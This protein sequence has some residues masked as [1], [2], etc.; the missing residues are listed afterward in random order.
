[1]SGVVHATFGCGWAREVRALRV[2]A[3]LSI[4]RLATAA[5]IDDAYLGQIERGEREPS[6]TVLVAI[7]TALGGDASVRLYPGTGPRLRDPIQARIVEAILR[8]ADPHWIRMV[9]VVVRRPVRG[10]IDLVLRDPVEPTWIAIEIH[11]ELRRLEQQLRWAN[12]KA[13][14]LPSSD[15]WPSSTTI[16]P[17]IHRVLVL[18]RTRANRTL[19]TRFEAML[20]AAYPA[21]PTDAYR[22]LTRPDLPWPGSAF[23]WATVDGDVTRISDRSIA[24]PRPTRP[25]RTAPE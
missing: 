3:G 10:V 23:L 15:A 20:S 16:E 4:R 24:T 5:R 8:T 11:S 2:D 1:M 21:S 18:R 19:A 25:H 12:E 14:A 17:T 9:E 6:L 22:A 13:R 7:A